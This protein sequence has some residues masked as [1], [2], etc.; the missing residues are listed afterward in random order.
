MRFCLS[1]DLGSE[2]DYTA[3]SLIKRVEKIQDKGIPS[4]NSRPFRDEPT[5]VIAELHL[6][7][8]ERVPLKTPY[9]KIVEKIGYIVNRPEFVDN[10]AL[11]IDKTG[12][13]IPVIQMMY[14]AGLAPIGISIHGGERVTTSKTDYGV[15]KRDLVTALL[16]AFQLRRFKMPPPSKLPIIKEF[17]EE[18][19][20]FQMKM[21]AKTGHDSY[22]AWLERIHDDLVISAALGVWWM[23]KTHG[24]STTLEA[25]R[26]K[27]S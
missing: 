18:L 25:K 13:G 24:V 16:A 10:I 8:M 7:H 6:T 26:A 20:N 4:F 19:T 14:Q 11:V 1:V 5:I 21:N 3:F 22:E 17:S 12:V 15:P 27:P 2:N 9:A 23:D